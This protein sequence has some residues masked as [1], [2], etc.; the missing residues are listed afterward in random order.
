MA[1]FCL[2]CLVVYLILTNSH[3]DHRSEFDFV[4]DLLSSPFD[5]RFNNLLARLREHQK[6]FDIDLRAGRWN[7]LAPFIRKVEQHV[8]ERDSI[9]NDVERR[10]ELEEE[11]IA[12]NSKIRNL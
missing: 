10:E 6:L 11:K 3:V 12:R 7:H 2:E 8:Q 4:K 9:S 5:L 1:S